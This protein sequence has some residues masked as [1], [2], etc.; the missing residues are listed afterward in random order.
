MAD[1]GWLN[2]SRRDFGIRAGLNVVQGKV[3]YAGV[4]EAFGLEYTPVEDLLQE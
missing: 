3:C 4:A 2:A 1:S